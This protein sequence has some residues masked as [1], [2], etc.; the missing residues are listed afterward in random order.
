MEVV[1]L[2]QVSSSSNSDVTDT[3]QTATAK[4]SGVV[5]RILEL[6]KRRQQQSGILATIILFT[7]LLY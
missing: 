7:G 5:G 1:T 3:K 4:S 2:E 6:K